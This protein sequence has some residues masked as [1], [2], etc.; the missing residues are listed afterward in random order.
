MSHSTGAFPTSLRFPG[1]LISVANSMPRSIC[2]RLQPST[3]AMEIVKTPIAKKARMVGGEVLGDHFCGFGGGVFKE[4]LGLGSTVSDA[5]EA[6][7]LP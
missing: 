4:A 3:T 7:N 2:N 5:I 1:A 6:L